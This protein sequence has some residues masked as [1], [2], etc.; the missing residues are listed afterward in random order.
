MR[1]AEALNETDGPAAALPYLNQVGR[2]VNP[3]AADRAFY[4]PEPGPPEP[5]VLNPAPFSTGRPCDRWNPTEAEK[6]KALKFI[7]F[8]GF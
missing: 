5:R 7:E 8:E 4:Q 6:R 1:Y 3:R 2:R